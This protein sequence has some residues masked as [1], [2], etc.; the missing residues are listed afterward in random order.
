MT[1]PTFRA[2]PTHSDNLSS[3]SVIVTL[4]PFT[5]VLHLCLAVIL[6]I[7]TSPPPIFAATT[8][9][10]DPRACAPAR[11]RDDTRHR[12]PRTAGMA[13]RHARRLTA[14][15]DGDNFTTYK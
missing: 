5:P 7:E 15:C 1:G 14:L 12:K 10:N 3:S 4:L 13:P 8:A 6:F 2:T 9:I 11:P